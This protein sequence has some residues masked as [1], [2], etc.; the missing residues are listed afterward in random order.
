[1][2]YDE[3]CNEVELII[4]SIFIHCSTFSVCFPAQPVD[5]ELEYIHMHQ[6]SHEHRTRIREMAPSLSTVQ[7][8]DSSMEQCQSDDR[9]Y[10]QPHKRPMAHHDIVRPEYGITRLPS[11]QSDR[12][13]IRTPQSSE[14][15]ISRTPQQSDHRLASHLPQREMSEPGP[16][17]YDEFRLGIG[18][19]TATFIWESLIS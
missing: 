8:S 16:P 17:C 18:N 1:M 4:R 3:T 5:D 9:L 6:P 11:T 14:R 13:T 15:H 2:L 19:P 12:L 10:R 7:L